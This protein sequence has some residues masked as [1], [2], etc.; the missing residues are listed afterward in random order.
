METFVVVMLFVLGAVLGSF[1]GVLVSRYDPD[2]PLFSSAIFG[3]S[4]CMSCKKTLHP[5]D[6]VPVLSYVF[7]LGRCRTCKTR[8]PF[9]NFFIELISGSIVA[10]VPAFLVRFYNIPFSQFFL[11]GALWWQYL[12][13]G[14][15]ICVFLAWLSM[16]MIDV[17]HYIIPDEFHVIFIV[18]GLMIAGIIIGYREDIFPFRESFLKNYTLVFSPFT[19]VIANRILGCLLSGIFFL[20][21]FVV[22]GGRGMGMGDVKLAFSTGILLGWPDMGLSIIVSFIIGGVLSSILFI[23]RRKTMKD[24]V[25]FAPFFVAG[26]VITI[27]FGYE[28][29]EWYFSIFGL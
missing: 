20:F 25:P 8:I 13:V 29:I 28:I 21:L 5:I 9:Q 19:G 11:G 12:L 2:K 10:G 18:L 16:V 14:L 22:S 17:K 1:L 23:A 7:L 26:F 6:L 24:R 15:W 4:R 27:F 3:R